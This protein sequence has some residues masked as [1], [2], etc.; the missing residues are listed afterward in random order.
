[1][2][3]KWWVKLIKFPFRVALET[4]VAILVLAFFFQWLASYNPNYYE[5]LTKWVNQP[6]VPSVTHCSVKNMDSSDLKAFPE[7][8]EFRRSC[9]TVKFSKMLEADNKIFIQQQEDKSF[10]YNQCKAKRPTS[11]DTSYLLFQNDKQRDELEIGYVSIKLSDALTEGSKNSDAC[12]IDPIIL[13]R[14][15]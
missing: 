14:K 7:T 12:P 13:G 10:I 1:M 8:S 3:Q 2:C 9:I 11:N 15:K 5:F 4:L 6:Y